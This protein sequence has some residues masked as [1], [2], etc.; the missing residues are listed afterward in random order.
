MMPVGDALAYNESDTRAKLIDPAIRGCGWTEG[1]TEALENPDVFEVPEVAKVGG[2][3][4][5]KAAG[6]PADILREAKERM[7]AA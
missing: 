3:E 6:K 1:G 4:A 7:F 5:L 2:F